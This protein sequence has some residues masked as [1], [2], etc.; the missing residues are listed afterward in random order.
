LV[1]SFFIQNLLAET[2]GPVGIAKVGQIRSALAMLM[3]TSSFGIFNGIVKYTAE[4]KDEKEQLQKM[5]STAFIFLLFGVLI[6]SSILFFFSETIS[7]YLFSSEDYNN[8]I[9]ILAFVVP[10]ISLTVLFK[11]VL[12][13]LT[14]YKKYAKIEL[15]SYLLSSALLII[16]L[17]KFSLLGVLIAIA[18]TPVLQ[19][20]VIVVVFGKTLKQHI[21][22]TGI[23]WNTPFAKALLTFTIMSV[24]STVLLN[25]IEIDIRAQISTKINEAEAGYWTAMLFVS[26]NYMVFSTGLFT[27][28]VMPKFAGIH[29]GKAFKKQVIHIYK[30]LLPLFGLGMLFIYIFRSFLIAIVYPGFEAME[31][32]FKWQLLGDFIKLIAVV[33]SYQFIAKRMLVS[34]VVTEIVSLGLF[35]FL[36]LY[37]VDE[38][39]TEGVTMAHLYR[40]I[41]YLF[42]VVI[43]V[44]YHFKTKNNIEKAE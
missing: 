24:I 16:S 22:V 2:I 11:G 20:I 36:S 5:F 38:Y 41:V 3:S 26:K 4:L 34:F 17:L 37:L 39:G 30:T 23:K 35:Y 8:V 43:A 33:L 14:A 29:G 19:L 44:W 40:Y 25:Y 13:G 9:K 7:I 21:S 10:A 1:I 18:I 32:L 28:Y 12:N 6:S 27:L 31:P 15:I 42:V